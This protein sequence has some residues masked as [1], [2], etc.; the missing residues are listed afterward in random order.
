MIVYNKSERNSP[1]L[2][3]NREMSAYAWPRPI[4]L[5][6]R[7]KLGNDRILSIGAV[8]RA[9]NQGVHRDEEGVHRSRFHQAFLL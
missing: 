7:M 1:A 8:D 2:Y 4:P 9:Q 5:H 3:I 6:Q